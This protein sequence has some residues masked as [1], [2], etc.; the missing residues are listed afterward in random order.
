MSKNLIDFLSIFIPIRLF[1]DLQDI[2][3]LIPLDFLGI[4]LASL[5]IMVLSSLTP[6]NNL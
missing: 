3:K 4:S 6:P 2:F 1:L 5:R